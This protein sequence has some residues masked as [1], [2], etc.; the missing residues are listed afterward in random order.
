MSGNFRI[1]TIITESPKEVATEADRLSKLH[2]R[3]RRLHAVVPDPRRLHIRVRRYG[4]Y[5]VYHCRRRPFVEFLHLSIHIKK[6]I[7]FFNLD[8]RIQWWF[9]RT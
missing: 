4:S 7:Q 1:G 3:R 9:K 5:V 8:L 6:T 2:L